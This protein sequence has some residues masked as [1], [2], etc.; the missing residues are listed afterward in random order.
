MLL[1]IIHAY[2]KPVNIKVHRDKWLYQDMTDNQRK[3]AFGVIS[4]L[5]YLVNAL[6]P[7]NT[8]KEEILQLFTNHP[9]VP[10]YMLGFTGDWKDNPIW[11]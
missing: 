11:K 10:V 7:N 3:R 9:K 5:L 8:L 4:C 6:N 2:G 1:L